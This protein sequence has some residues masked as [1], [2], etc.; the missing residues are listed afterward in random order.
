[1]NIERFRK[2]YDICRQSWYGDDII[3][4]VRGFFFRDL[5]RQKLKIINY[6]SVRFVYKEVIG[7][8]NIMIVGKHS[9]LNR[10]ALKIGGCNNE[11]V[12]GD[13]CRFGHGCRILLLG[14]NMKLHIGD[15]SSFSHDDELLVQEDG[16]KIKI[17][18]DCMFSHHI[19]VRTSDAH[20]I[21]DIQTGERSNKAKD[22]IIGNHVWI[23]AHCIIQKGCQIG[24]GSIIATHSVVTK[25]IPDNCVAAGIPAKVVKENVRWERK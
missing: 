24:S 15:N 22:V 6:G 23:T 1:M 7:G 9:L 18:D 14:N 17:G 12:I 11:I 13:G 19:N 16:V 4:F 3:K 2:L 20:P 8:G 25:S 21:Y 10:V 5:F